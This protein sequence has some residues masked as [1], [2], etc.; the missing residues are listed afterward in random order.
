M[1]SSSAAKP[2]CGVSIQI[3]RSCSDVDVGQIALF[4]EPLTALPRFALAHPH[5]E[6]LL[7]LVGPGLAARDR[8]QPA[9][10]G[11]HGSAPQLLGAHLA[12]TLAA[13]HA[14]AGISDSLAAQLLELRIELGLIEPI[15]LARGALAGR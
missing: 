10:T 7:R 2:A 13:A 4:F 6:P 3:L 5:A 14:P 9:V 1:L 15:Q 11:M 12:Q 8:Q